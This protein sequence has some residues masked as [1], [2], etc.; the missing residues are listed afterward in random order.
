M[1]LRIT[2]LIENNPDDK[3][4]L[5]NEH[6]LSLYIEVDGINILFDTGQTGDFIRNAEILK[7]DLNILDYIIISHGHYDHSGGLKKL[8]NKLSKYPRLIVGEEF[9]KPKYKRIDKQTFKY[10]GNPLDEGFILDNN[11]FF[12]MVKE[13]IFYISENIMVFHH[14][15][16]RNNFEKRNDKFFIVEKDLIIHDDFDD[17]IV[18]GV[19]TKKGMVVIVGCSHVGIANILT[20][21]S[22]KTGIPIYS[23]VGGTHLFEAD[24]NRMQKTIELFHSMNIKMIALSHCTGE[25]GIKRIQEE[26]TKEFIYNNTG[27]IIVIDD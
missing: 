21:I 9:F 15:T 8:V 6:G 13:D 26:F 4:R 17:E 5:I 22:E 7:K 20:S 14:F 12:N 18:L 1:K 2:T 27:N 23:V 25:Q 16:R 10:N 11:I 19:V 24:E 3:K